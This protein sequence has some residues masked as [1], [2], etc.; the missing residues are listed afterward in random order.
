MQDVFLC[1]VK[2][3]LVINDACG[4]DIEEHA[5]CIAVGQELQS[6]GRA[7]VGFAGEDDDHV[8]FLGIIHYEVA[9]RS[10][11]QKQDRGKNCDQKNAQR[12]HQ[13]FL[14]RSDKSGNESNNY[15]RA[16]THKTPD[17]TC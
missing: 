14:S 7:P 6:A 3:A 8:S 5:R 4:W 12:A 16:C 17:S 15:G 9:S 2:H 10:Q 13:V 11:R 1:D